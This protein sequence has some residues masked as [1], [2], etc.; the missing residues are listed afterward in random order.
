LQF[1]FG[2]F[3]RIKPAFPGWNG[4]FEHLAPDS[5]IRVSTLQRVGRGNDDGPDG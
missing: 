1:R 2:Q 3:Y 5:D 4:V